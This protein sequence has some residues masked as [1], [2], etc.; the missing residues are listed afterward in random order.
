M[1]S[2]HT[3]ITAHLHGVPRTLD[4]VSDALAES[5]DNYLQP[6]PGEMYAENTTRSP[7]PATNQIH[8]SQQDIHEIHLPTD[9]TRINLLRSVTIFLFL[10]WDIVEQA[11][12]F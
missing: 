7:P 4:L 2:A 1:S 11:M 10:D 6:T 3:D 8:V 5:T 9:K 12:W